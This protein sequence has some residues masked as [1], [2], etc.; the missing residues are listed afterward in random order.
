MVQPK[1]EY[2]VGMSLR[3][4]AFVW[5][6]LSWWIPTSV[7]Q[8]SYEPLGSPNAT[9]VDRAI[10]LNGIPGSLHTSIYP[11]RRGDMA[12]IA[13][14]MLTQ[15]RTKIQEKRLLRILMDNNEF[16]TPQVR[17]YWE[18]DAAVDS[19]YYNTTTKDFTIF[20]SLGHVQYQNSLASKKTFLKI[21]Y[22]TPAHLYEMDKKD[23]YLRINPMI[24]FHLGK[25]RGD[26]DLLFIN[27]R[28]IEVRGGIDGRVFFYT[29]IVETQMRPA[30][31]YRWFKSRYDVLPDAGLVKNYQSSIFD[32]DDGYDYLN[33]DGY[34][35]FNISKHVG[36]HFGHGKNFIGD[37][38]RS[39]FLS[40]FSKNYFYLKFNTRVWKFHYQNIFAELAEKART[41]KTEP[42][43]KKFMAAHFLS[44]QATKTLSFGLF[45]SVIFDRD[46]G[47]FE[48]QYL[49][50]IILYAYK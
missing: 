46:N 7:A 37:G 22:K 11:Y 5:L 25:E 14:F 8:N 38:Y 44:F 20:D 47:Q 42:Y 31:H 49:N 10:I 15:P 43:P 23:F 19:I 1:S 21:F 28:G 30:T 35:G 32:F 9:T 17:E 18:H 39:M 3:A 36:V 4:I 45:E 48:F 13:A 27:Q 2:K 34:V 33:A 40:D 16:L 50:P 12:E 24:N 26:E 41:S 29:N 6:M